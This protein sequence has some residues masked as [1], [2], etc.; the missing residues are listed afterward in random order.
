MSVV[1]VVYPYSPRKWQVDLH[2]GKKRLNIAICHRRAGK[3]WA[4]LHEL[5]HCAL[6]ESGKEFCY[7]APYLNQA[8]KVLWAPLVEKALKIP[9]TD[10]RAS[11]LCVR[12]PNGSKIWVFGADN[13]DGLRGMGMDGIVADEFQLWD[14]N[15]LPAVFLPML[16]GRQD[17]WLLKLGTPTGIDPL[18]VD[19]DKAAGDPAWAR[20]KF[21][22]SDTGVFSA[23]ELQTIRGNMPENLFRL[24]Y[25]C[26]FDA[27]SPRQLITGDE[28][29]AAM[30]RSYEPEV[31]RDQARI[32][33]A[34]IARQGDD[35]SVIARRQGLQVWELEAWQS[36]D[37]M[38]T[39][40]R[41]AEG[42]HA[43]KP[44]ALFIDAGGLGAGVL[45][46]LRSLDI[47]AIEVQFGA[48]ASDPRWKNLR[49]EMWINLSNWIR[50][51]G[52]LPPDPSLKLELTA[53]QYQT[54]DSGQTKLES[55]EDLRSRGMKSPDRADAVAMTFAYPVHPV[56]HKDQQPSKCVTDWDIWNR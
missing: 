49:A 15:T 1:N 43:Y 35:F 38:V 36:P 52:R 18:T 26:D 22:A 56:S 31:Y 53:V 55:K 20:F 12:F 32:M 21:A 17:S 29:K 13:A 47:P 34:D 5:L 6:Q 14:Q 19:Y 28:V 10:V 44:D 46:Y 51:G 41:I 2:R 30:E 11:D 24:E 9:G 40:R 8:K 7:V 16:S 37:L 25:M 42:Y 4:A 33:A 54:A 39:A 3:T 45:D 50:R 48:A 27:G 23:E